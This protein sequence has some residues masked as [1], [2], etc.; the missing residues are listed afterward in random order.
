MSGPYT[1]HNIGRAPTDSNCTSVFTFIIFYTL[2]PTPTEVLALVCTFV[3]TLAK[4]FIS[5]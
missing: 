1:C 2:T 3:F 4:V 5:T